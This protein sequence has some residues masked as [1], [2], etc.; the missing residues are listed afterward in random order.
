MIEFI[1]SG[2]S[3]SLEILVPDVVERMRN[4]TSNETIFNL[5]LEK[6]VQ[7][8]KNFFIRQPYIQAF[9]Y[10]NL[11]THTGIHDPVD[12][13]ESVKT[14]SF[15]EFNEFTKEWLNSIQLKWLVF[16][17]YTEQTALKIV[18]ECESRLIG[19]GGQ[20]RDILTIQSENLDEQ[21]VVEF[22]E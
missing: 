21:R 20:K 3:S 17:N 14:I 11:V 18:D 6:L 12:L 7:L 5:Q 16:G 15:K 22:L 19:V 9:R 10:K 1:F 13:Y 2:F 8:Y 4:F